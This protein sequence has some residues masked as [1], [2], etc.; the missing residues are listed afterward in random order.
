MSLPGSQARYGARLLGP[1]HPDTLSSANNLAI[2][3]KSLG[4]RQ[5]ARDLDQDTLNRYRRVLGDDH[6]GTLASA[7]NLA[8]D[9]KS[10]GEH[11]A[12]RDLDQD[13]L[14]RRRRV[15]GPGHPSTLTSAHNLAI[16]L[17]NLG[18]TSTAESRSAQ[19]AGDRHGCCTLRCTTSGSGAD[20]PSRPR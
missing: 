19:V 1:E 15:L 10:L 6:P 13:T 8:A 2:D 7:H 3:L 20:L 12:A 18:G 4:D 9:L 11:Q 16:D 17:G 14:D 5:A